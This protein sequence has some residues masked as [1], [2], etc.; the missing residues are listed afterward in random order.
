MHLIS[1]SEPLVA[2]IILGNPLISELNITI[3]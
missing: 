3:F 1:Y 2:Y